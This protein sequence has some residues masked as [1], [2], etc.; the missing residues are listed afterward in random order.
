M[1]LALRGDPENILSLERLFPSARA[2]YQ[3]LITHRMQLPAVRFGV[4]QHHADLLASRQALEVV[5]GIPGL[6]GEGEDWDQKEK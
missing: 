1:S 4:V 2:D 5:P 3:S 6:L